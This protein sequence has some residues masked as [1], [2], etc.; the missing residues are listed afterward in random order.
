VVETPNLVGTGADQRRDSGF[1][2]G[3]ALLF[4]V[5]AGTSVVFHEPWRD[6]AQ[7][8]LIARDSGG[9]GA[10]FAN[11]RYEGVP[12]L[13]HALLLPLTRLGPPCLMSGLNLALAATAVFVFA[14]F[15]PFDR[16]A[17]ALFAFGYL[18]IYE[19][20]TIARNYAL[21]VVFLFLFAV[22]FSRR[23]LILQGL[24]LAAAANTSA[25][26]A[27]VAASALTLVLVDGASR[28]R[29]SGCRKSGAAYGAG[30]ALAAVGILASVLQMTPP[31]NMGMPWIEPPSL[32]RLWSVVCSFP[33]GIAPF[34]DC[35]FGKVEGLV[36]PWIA[37]PLT[38]AAVLLTL[39]FIVVASAYLLHRRA[40]WIVAA[41]ALSMLCGL[42]FFFGWRGPRHAG[43]LLIGL[44]L[45]L[46]LAPL[47]PERRPLPGRGA[48]WMAALQRQMPRVLGALLAFQCLVA[49]LAVTVE[50]CTVFSAARDTA[51][52]IRA[53]GHSGLP[54]VVD[55]DITAAGIVAHLGAPT[56]Y[57]PN[58]HRWGSFVVWR[59][60]MNDRSAVSADDAGIFHQVSRLGI[61]SDVVVVLGHSVDTDVQARVGA[62]L[63]G[64]ASADVVHEESYWV[65]R[66][67]GIMEVW[68]PGGAPSVRE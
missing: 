8:W 5:V 11:C 16:K 48:Q 26:A 40:V 25:H 23:R 39:A 36:S 63:I 27:I 29:Q 54:L 20:G 12:A 57:Y 14:R 28:S 53:S 67:M 7:A 45:A 10:L 22:F 43:F 51:R 13:W 34:A 17:R 35:W 3:I 37:V 38:V 49:G 64:H 31:G 19:W 15:A 50:I 62:E 47:F 1:A 61:N 2:L 30:I 59:E 24:V 66:R 44:L 9:L 4:L 55:P 6:E 52:M 33:A 46:W 56:A 58:V 21:G 18:P 41:S 65:Y 68:R 32:H 60:H 42:F